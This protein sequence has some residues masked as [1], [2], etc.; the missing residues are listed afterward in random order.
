MSGGQRKAAVAA[1]EHIVTPL[2]AAAATAARRGRGTEEE[3][4]RG[5]F[6]DIY[7]VTSRTLTWMNRYVLVDR[8]QV[9]LIFLSILLLVF[10]RVACMMLFFLFFLFF[11][12]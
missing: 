6:S 2:A 5:R 12:S 11:L 10:A 7:P 4:T 9:S 1:G 8:V 3:V